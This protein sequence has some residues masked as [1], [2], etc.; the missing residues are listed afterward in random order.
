M[1][2]ESLDL[3]NF[4]SSHSPDTA[5]LA[6]AFFSNDDIGA[7]IR[8]HFELER[9]ATHALD[10]LTQGR[11]KAAKCRYLNDKLNALEMIGAPPTIL[12]SAKILNRHRNRLAHDGVDTISSEQEAEFTLSVRS[13]MPQYT[14]DFR[15]I[16]SGSMNFDDKVSNC[17]VRQRYVISCGFVVMLVGSIPQIM[18]MAL[19][20]VK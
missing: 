16:I 17:T 5:R 11:W 7:L 1:D 6:A 15:V 14:D 19:Q 13:V 10:V 12:A 8:C 18:A 3:G 2:K 20:K 9:A 4:V